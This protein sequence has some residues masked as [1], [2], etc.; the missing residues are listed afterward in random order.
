MSTSFQWYPS[1]RS[2]FESTI[3]SYLDNHVGIS[4]NFLSASLASHLRDNLLRLYE[5][6]K[7]EK[8]R[9]GNNTKLQ[10]N[11]AIRKDLIYWLDRRHNDEHE[12]T[13]FDLMDEFIKYLNQTCYT[14]ITNCEFHYALY[15]P[16]SYYK[17]HFDQFQE[18]GKRAYSMI[19]YL[20]ENWQ[21]GDGGELTIYKNEETITI[22]P[23]HGKSVFF[24]SDQLEH[25]VLMSHK[26]RMSITGWLRT[27]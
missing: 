4:E 20:N 12:N 18:G 9:I 5:S 11:E 16:G 19:M 6:S 10:S 22:T 3:A 24:K 13:F 23:I 14:R 26:P 15:E 17:R 27:D 1:M 21:E 7:L 25:E 8:A 2:I